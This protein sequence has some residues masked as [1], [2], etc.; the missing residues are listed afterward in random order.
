VFQNAV[1]YNMPGHEVHVRAKELFDAFVGRWKHAASRPPL[2]HL[3]ECAALQLR[4]HTGGASNGGGAAPASARATIDEQNG[5]GGEDVTMGGG[6]AFRMRDVARRRTAPPSTCMV[7]TSTDGGGGA[8][9][10]YGGALDLH[11]D[12]QVAATSA[13]LAAKE[14]EVWSLRDALKKERETN[15]ELARKEQEL[16]EL[17]SVHRD[18]ET[19][20]RRLAMEARTALAEQRAL[21]TAERAMHAELAHKYQELLSSS[22]A[23]GKRL[24][25][26]CSKAAGGAKV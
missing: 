15:V 11:G 24:P 1:T 5:K 25:R 9:V 20:A 8:L 16:T 4:L 13:A 26:S 22:R 18:L 14:A 10:P 17:L 23:D 7:D 6:E 3:P 12:A 19:E 21:L 2:D